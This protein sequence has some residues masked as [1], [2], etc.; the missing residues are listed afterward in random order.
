MSATTERRYLDF[1]ARAKSNGAAMLSFHCPH[2]N[3]EILTPAA[4]VGDAWNSMSTCPYCE[5]LFM[6]VTTN[7]CVKTGVLSPDATVIWGE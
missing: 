3:S 6:K 4:P 7:H 2:C 1:I 5:G